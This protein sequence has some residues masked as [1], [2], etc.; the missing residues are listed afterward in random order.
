MES[1]LWALNL[2]VV[3]YACIWALREDGALP[4]KKK[5]G[6]LPDA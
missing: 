3:A 5:K 4:S 6:K 1:L 2:V